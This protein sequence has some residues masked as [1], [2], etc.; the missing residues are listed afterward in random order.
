MQNEN[1]EKTESSA[2][3][4]EYLLE[5]KNL[6]TFFKTQKGLVKAVNDVSYSLKAG[7]DNKR[8]YSHLLFRHEH[9]RHRKQCRYYS[10]CVLFL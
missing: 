6:H 10:C 9:N 7:S 2:E 5:V 8:D 3:Q 1:I 4:N